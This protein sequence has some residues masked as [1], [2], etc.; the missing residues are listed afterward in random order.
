MNFTT[1][2][3]YFFEDLLIKLYTL[4][5][6]SSKQCN[7]YLFGTISFL[8]KASELLFSQKILAIVIQKLV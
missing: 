2:L 1:K 7:P 6:T 4:H 5:S 3:T 8:Q